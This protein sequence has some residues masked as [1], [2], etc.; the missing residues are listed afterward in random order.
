MITLQKAQYQHDCPKCK[1]LGISSDKRAD[2]YACE[3]D[4]GVE[5]IARYSDEPSNNVSWEGT[6]RG[7]NPH[8]IEARFLYSVM[9]I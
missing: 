6:M 1:F 4:Y 2:L 9:G 3:T 7:G 5:L 8:I